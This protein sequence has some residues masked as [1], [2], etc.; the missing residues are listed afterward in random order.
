MR[1]AI[2]LCAAATT[3]YFHHGVATDVSVRIESTKD[4]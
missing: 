2:L 3:P 4:E 1:T